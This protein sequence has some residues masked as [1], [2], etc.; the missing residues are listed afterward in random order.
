MNLRNTVPLITLLFLVG[1]GETSQ[2]VDTSVP[3]SEPPVPETPPEPPKPESTLRLLSCSD[4]GEGDFELILDT[5]DFS[6][7]SPMATYRLKKLNYDPDKLVNDDGLTMGENRGVGNKYSIPFRTTPDS[8]DFS[9]LLFP[10]CDYTERSKRMNSCDMKFKYSISRET[11]SGKNEFGQPVTCQIE[12]YED[13][14][15]QI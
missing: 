4:E 15:N 3:E 14:T 10:G 13:S 6:K 5:Q 1:C 7:D 2:E 8:I 9:V 11:L 12:V